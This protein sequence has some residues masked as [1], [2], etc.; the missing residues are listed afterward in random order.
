M[1]MV[2]RAT[3]RA[4]WTGHATHE[5]R[6]SKAVMR[7]HLR[8]HL[9]RVNTKTTRLVAFIDNLHLS[10]QPCG[11]AGHQVQRYQPDDCNHNPA[12]RVWLGFVAPH[13][14][15]ASTSLLPPVMRS[16]RSQCF[17]AAEQLQR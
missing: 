13:F 16:A 9:A 1:M 2:T 4:A 6:M 15:L 10:S 12:P 7:L 5:V 3:A 8:L 14:D 17:E 11:S